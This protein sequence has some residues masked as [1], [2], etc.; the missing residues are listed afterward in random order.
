MRGERALATKIPP[1]DPVQLT[2]FQDNAKSLLSPHHI[3][4]TPEP[5]A[6][7]FLFDARMFLPTLSAAFTGTAKDVQTGTPLDRAATVLSLIG[8][9]IKVAWLDTNNHVGA[10]SRHYYGGC[11]AVGSSTVTALS[12]R[13]HK[14]LLG[15]LDET[16]GQM[17]VM[18]HE[19]THCLDSRLLGPVPLPQ[20]ASSAYETTVNERTADA[21]ATLWM[22]ARTK[23]PDERQKTLRMV[24][25]MRDARLLDSRQTH[26][27]YSAIDRALDFA[28]HNPLPELTPD[29]MT[30]FAAK[31]R[32]L[33]LADMLP[34]AQYDA[35]WSDMRKKDWVTKNN[36]D[37]AARK[38]SLHELFVRRKAEKADDLRKTQ[39]AQPQAQM[40][41]ARP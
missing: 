16:L 13:T 17:F 39:P 2:Q 5:D 19:S 11:V 12:G 7:R 33:A 18:A 6:N 15:D 21:G 10:F 32:E 37:I 14:A 1:V 3:T 8:F 36:P 25:F 40:A 9:P 31:A 4:L 30:W 35:F 38:T 41:K 27:T 23:T 26:D 34:P 29:T 24:I 20:G 22:L 28:A